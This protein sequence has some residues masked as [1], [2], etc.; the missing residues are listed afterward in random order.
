MPWN[1]RPWGCG[2]GSKGSCNSGWIQFEICEDDLTDLNYFAAAYKEAC[3]LTAYLCKM[4]NINPKGSVVVNGVSIPTILCH[5]DSHKLGMGSNHGDVNHWFPKYGKSME[6]ARNDVAE[7]MGTINTVTPDTNTTTTVPA[8]K[9]SLGDEVKLVP[10]STYSS[11]KTIPN[12]VFDSKLYVREIRSNGTIIISTVATGPITGVVNADSL[13]PY[14]GNVAAAAPDVF[15]PFLVQITA[16]AL[17]VRANAGLEYKI[18][19]QV[20]KNEIYTIIEEKSGWGKL[21]SGIGWINLDYTTRYN[22]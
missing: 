2:S 18:K 11:G 22:P 10:G 4:F 19:A 7:L 16:T 8:S 14:G 1:F 20:H 13:I 6:T 15:E 5:A 9:F 3:E 17:N 21:K 12:W